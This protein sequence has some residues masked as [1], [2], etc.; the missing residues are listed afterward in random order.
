MAKNEIVIPVNS[1]VS[2]HLY[3]ESTGETLFEIPDA[4]ENGE[5]PFQIK[6]GCFY[7]YK[8]T[9]GYSLSLS[10]V[11]S[12]SKVNGSAGRI[13]PNI[14]VG[15]LSIDVLDNKKTKCGEVKLEVQ[16]VKSTYRQDYRQ[17]LEEI[18]EKCV[19]LLLQHS[20]PVSQYFEVDPNADAATLY[21]R[22]AFV[23]SIIDS[24]EFQDAVHKIVASPVTRWKESEVVKDIRSVKRFNSS[25][26][27]QLSSAGN[28]IELQEAHPLYERLRSIPSKIRVNNK[29]ETVDT[30]ENRFIKHVLVYF[31][32][33]CSDFET[34]LKDSSRLKTE[35]GLLVDKLEQLLSHSVFKEISTPTTLPLNS[36]VLQ[37]KEG[38]R[39]VLRVWLM[40]D[41]A[42]K[43][44]WHG[45]DDV[46]S[47]NK[48]DVAVL[49]EYWL[50]FKLLDIIKVV[51]KIDALATKDLVE[52]T[53]DGLGLK[54]KQ[55]KYLPI[56][57]IYDSENRK[58]R[59]EFSYNKTF[60][61]DK[62][63]PAGG[64]WSRS[65][66]PDYTLSIWPDG[67]EQAQAEA[68]ELIVH[69]HFDAKYK[70]ENLQMIFGKEETS[71]EEREKNLEEEEKEQKTGTYK[72]ADIL[73][74]HT[75]RDAIRRT[76]GAYVLYPGSVSV[77]KE[78]FHELLPGLGAFAIRPSKS[79]NG[80]EAL[81]KFLNEVVTHFMNRASQREKISLKTYETYK[82]KK[83]NE[84]NQPLPEPYGLNR[85]LIPDETFVLVAYYKKDKLDW[86]ISSGLY[87]ARA[88]SKRGSLR[89]GPGE[90]GAKYLLLHTEGELVTGK[91]FKITETGPR[92]FSKQTLIEKGYPAPTQ[93]FYLVYKVEEVR[94]KEFANQFWDIRKLNGYK[95]GHGSP[96]PF[97]VTMTELMNAKPG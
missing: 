11:V 35:A 82:D 7:E 93:D 1:T 49:Y 39:E 96:L 79:D 83:A 4:I 20:S 45:G 69:I 92:I 2:L 50:F 75:Y 24:A 40:F 51:F 68:E 89:L 55:G 63:Y 17:M 71:D 42:A 32:S 25:A 65:L 74:M 87:N 81:I 97:S 56:Q 5:A 72:R 95:T 46:Y 61:G 34:K 47:G 78:G 77:T 94:E 26:I 18:T 67:I 48:R 88:D 53:K 13:S 31:Q 12:Q 54:L 43:M 66:R 37:R 62:K 58:L 36:P 41:L 59:V 30:P 64:S 9:D 14:Y 10:E 15:T 90:A 23:R 8:I 16:S 80:S 33:F 85:S 21:Q 6:E 29:T 38:Y 52:T 44:V 91:L 60:S 22:F 73:K 70:I 19:D 84:V 3:G 57:G 76:A 27:R 86:I 28:R